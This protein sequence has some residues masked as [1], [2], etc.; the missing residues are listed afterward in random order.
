MVEVGEVDPDYRRNVVVI[1]RNHNKEK[2]YILDEGEPMAQVILTKEI[3]PEIMETK[4]ARDTERGTSG[5]GS[6]YQK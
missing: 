2:G 3:I 4:I 6:T 1:S 5:F